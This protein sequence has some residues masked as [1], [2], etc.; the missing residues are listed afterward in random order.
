MEMRLMLSVIATSESTIFVKP[1]IVIEEAKLMIVR[2]QD[3]HKIALTVEWL[4]NNLNIS[5]FQKL[6]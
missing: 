4:K 3:D 1:E 5:S 2:S 6:N